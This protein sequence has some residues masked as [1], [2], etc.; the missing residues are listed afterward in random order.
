MDRDVPKYAILSHTW[1]EEELSFHDMKNIARVNKKGWQKIRQ[2]CQ[3]AAEDGLEYAW[4]DTCSINKDSSAELTEA[5]NSMY[6]WY[7]R[8]DIC[9]VYLTDLPASASL[10][11]ALPKCKWFKR[12][13]TLQELIAPKT[14]SFFNKEWK[15]IGFKDDLI[16]LLSRI[17]K[18]PTQVLQQKQ[19]LSKIPVAQ[20]MSWAANRQ[21]TRVEDAAY[22]L[23][24]I[25]N[26]NMPLLYGEKGKAFRRLQEEIIRSTADLS[27]FAWNLPADIQCTPNPKGQSCC[28][29][30]AE[31][32]IAF[33]GSISIVENTTS[34]TNEFL[35]TNIGVK[36]QERLLIQR[37]NQQKNNS[38]YVLSL[39]CRN[40]KQKTVG[41]R[42]K[43]CGPEQY[44]REDP[45]R[46]VEMDDLPTLQ[47]KIRYLIIELPPPYVTDNW[48]ILNLSK[49]INQKRQTILHIKFPAPLSKKSCWPEDE[50]DDTESLFF[51][52]YNINRDARYVQLKG[53]MDVLIKDQRIV[54][55]LN[56]FF[57]AMDWTQQEGRTP[58][59]TLLPND[60][61][62]EDLPSKIVTGDLSV[63]QVVSLF[64]E[65]G[66]PWTS[67]LDVKIP[68][69][70]YVLKLSFK[71]S[72]DSDLNF[73]EEKFWRV[74][75]SYNKSQIRKDRFFANQKKPP[76]RE[77]SPNHP[78]QA[79]WRSSL[80]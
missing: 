54:I 6:Q 79:E 25:F 71:T 37:T 58:R 34:L 65:R 3:K 17:T 53:D 12:G 15:S 19:D 36:I 80:I 31:S 5:I 16:N 74:T 43:K 23:L 32:V 45:W 42:L 35:T 77:L 30:M 69:T 1:E 44:I 75:F 38:T 62:M 10:E 48:K 40:N 8:A 13:W 73:F 76:R 55:P 18:I 47:P 33:A 72:F 27:I 24:G 46:L 2:T 39:K 68:K 64:N 52:S 49:F 29:V 26:V 56:A 61:G 4:V 7:K 60:N 66:I 59:C 28:G 51:S 70:N 11:S 78:S 9:Y 67:E 22:S 21:T 50:W 14:V 63:H 57:W 41:I 20:K